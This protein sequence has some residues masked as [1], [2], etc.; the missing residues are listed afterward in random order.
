MARHTVGVQAIVGLLAENR[1]ETKQPVC[2]LSENKNHCKLQDAHCAFDEQTPA[3]L[4]PG[5]TY[6]THI[7]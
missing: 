7:S 6:S 5:Q 4:M 2:S 1:Q 3:R